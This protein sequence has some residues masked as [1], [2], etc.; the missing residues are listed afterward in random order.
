MAYSLRKIDTEDLRRIESEVGENDLSIDAIKY[1]LGQDLEVFWVVDEERRLYL[2]EIPSIVMDQR[3][4]QDYIFYNGSSYKLT[5]M[6]MFT[7]EVRLAN[8][9][10]LKSASIKSEITE[11]FSAH[12]RHAKLQ[13][14]PEKYPDNLF[15][16][17][18][19]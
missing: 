13:Q 2:I 1:C 7:S 4:D 9:S 14:E 10:A 15:I 3:L 8:L 11:A 18:F 5:A 19:I 12:G 17:V 6:S 16:P